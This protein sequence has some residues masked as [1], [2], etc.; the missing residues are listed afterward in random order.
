MTG[1]TAA[2]TDVAKL[3]SLAGTGTRV[4]LL[5]FVLTQVVLFASTMQ[6]LGQPW[7]G[8]I[9]LVLVVVAAVIA[10]RS[11][12]YP[13]PLL[14]MVLVIVA[15]AASTALVSWQLPTSGWAGYASWHLGANT[16]LLLAVSLRG[17]SGAA[18]IGMAI[19]T[20]ITLLWTVSTGQGIFAG[21]NLIDRQAGTLL[22]GTLFAIGLSRTAS[23]IAE[24]NFAES[25]RVVERMSLRVAIDER[26][27]QAARLQSTVLPTL[28]V[29]AGGKPLSPVER[30]EFL[31]VE[32]GLRDSI[33]ART[34]AREPLTSV[35]AEARRRGV[36]V[37]LLDDGRGELPVGEADRIAEWVA[38][39]LVELRDGSL[40]ARVLPSGR[41]AAATIVVV[42][43]DRTS[44]FELINR[45]DSQ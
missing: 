44:H 15:V 28:R 6:D 38:G 18:W 9:A 12:P 26:T 22:I 2:R 17:R 3:L 41:A 11:G 43:A 40:T 21:V 19:M 29:I 35:A 25:R 4:L 39:Q 42:T 5:I 1:P 27:K 30:A 31:I 10:T 8:A 20:A 13:L 14:S 7:L 16:F 33:R 32:A 36:E 45:A 24:F 37:L 34:L 23:R